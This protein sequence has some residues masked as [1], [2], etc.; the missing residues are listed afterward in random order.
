MCKCDG[1]LTWRLAIFLVMNSDGLISLLVLV[2]FLSANL[3]FISLKIFGVIK[4]KQPKS[5]FVRLLELIVIYFLVGGL[6]LYL[7][8]KVGQIAPQ[9]WE[10]YAVNALLMLTFSFPGFIYR[11]LLKR[12]PSLI[13]HD[14]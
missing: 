8:D 2:A 6:G 1:G 12:K 7:E 11:Y 10:F 4:P 5:L 14:G 13:T 3:P 9:G